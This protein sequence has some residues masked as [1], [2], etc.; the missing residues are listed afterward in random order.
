VL[1]KRAG[2]K[3]KKVLD[4]NKQAEEM[5]DFINFVRTHSYEAGDKLEELTKSI[6]EEGGKFHFEQGSTKI[7]VRGGPEHFRKIANDLKKSQGL[8]PLKF[9][10]DLIVQ[11]PD[12]FDIKDKN[13]QM[14]TLKQLKETLGN[15]FSEYSLN[16]DQGSE[17]PETSILLQVADDNA[18]FNGKRR[19]NI[20]NP[21]ATHVGIAYSK[22]KTK[23]FW[24][25]VFAS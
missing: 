14:N 2:A 13:W 12:A 6:A 8:S 3:K 25:L 22:Q 9:S 16:I 10:A 18:L 17:I 7:N 4:P 5:F 15:T 19:A 1:R 23:S 11:I 21:K 24:L 20:L